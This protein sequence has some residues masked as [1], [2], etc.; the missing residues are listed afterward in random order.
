MP[1]APTA[2]A[3][4]TKPSLEPFKADATQ[5][6]ALRDQ[7]LPL[8]PQQQPE[9]LSTT[10]TPGQAGTS[11]QEAQTT[12]ILFFFFFSKT[13]FIFPLLLYKYQFNLLL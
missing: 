4:A 12:Q 13:Y 7:T 6:P 1:R 11:H 10:S 8:F 2:G 3:A 5:H 9:P